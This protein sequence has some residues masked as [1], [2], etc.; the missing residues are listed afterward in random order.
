MPPE[1][2]TKG[3]DDEEKIKKRK[4]LTF[5]EKKEICEWKRDHPSYNLDEIAKK[6]GISK[7]QA[8]NIIKEK[9]KWTSINTSN[10]KSS[11]LKRERGAKF[12]EVEAALYLWMSQALASNLAISGDILKSKATHFAERLQVTSFGVSDGWLTKF[13]AHYNIKQYNKAGEANSAPLETLNDERVILREVIG[14]YDLCDVYN[15][16]ETGNCINIAKFI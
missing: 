8:G 7:S 14:E 6:F 15:I 1:K 9:D 5:L 4:S 10:V 13:K 16:D 3:S 11:N 12:P 2:R